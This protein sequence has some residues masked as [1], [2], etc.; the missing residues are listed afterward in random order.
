MFHLLQS[1]QLKKE[2]NAFKVCAEKHIYSKTSEYISEDTVN[3]KK[4][5]D[6]SEE[7]A[8][9]KKLPCRH[10]LRFVNTKSKLLI[11]LPIYILFRMGLFGAAHKWGP[12][13]DPPT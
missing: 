2:D 4:L 10:M 12:Q 11:C 7:T 1:V 8:H 3:I 6:I 5:Q 13:K 9:I